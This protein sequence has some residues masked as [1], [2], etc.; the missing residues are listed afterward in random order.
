VATPCGPPRSSTVLARPHPVEEPFGRAGGEKAP[1]RTR[2]RDVS[3]RPTYAT[4]AVYAHSHPRLAD[5]LAWIGGDRNQRPPST[6]A[7]WAR[8]AVTNGTAAACAA[9]AA[10]RPRE[11]ISP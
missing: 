2:A 1:S 10:R 5:R 8:P 4:A 9:R 7:A 6:A 11:A 3:V